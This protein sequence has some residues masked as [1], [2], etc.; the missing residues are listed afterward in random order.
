MDFIHIEGGNR[1]TGDVNIQGSKNSALPILAAAAAVDGIC[2]IEN[3]PR[4]TDVAAAVNILTY[5]GCAVTR[6]GETLTVD[7]RSMLRWDIPENL[8]HEMRS[9]IVFL[10]P[11][12]ARF[13]KAEVSMPGGCEIGLRPINLHLR[14]MEQFGVTV[15]ESGGRLLCTS[16]SRLRGA[17]ITLSFP[18]VGATEN[19]M[20]A[21]AT[22]Q[23]TTTLVNAAREPE[24][25]DLADF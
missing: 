16:Q 2:I 17:R 5:L 25:V 11:L 18:S 22:A 9:S 14:A 7:A 19:I 15:E 21:A 23:G 8:M 3:C 20:L 6:E 12:I 24:I 13:G 1:L 10:G 4:L